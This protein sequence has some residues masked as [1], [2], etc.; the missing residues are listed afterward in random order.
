[1][2]NNRFSIQEKKNANQRSVGYRRGF[3]W[4]SVISFLTQPGFAPAPGS[5]A[6]SMP[7]PWRYEKTR[8]VVNAK[9]KFPNRF[10]RAAIFRAVFLGIRDRKIVWSGPFRSG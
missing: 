8:F 5:G 3:S 1:M 9:S 7:E 10:N 4:L 6:K 2:E